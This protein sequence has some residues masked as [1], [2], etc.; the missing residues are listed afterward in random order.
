VINVDL[1][2]SGIEWIGKIP[3][4]WGVRTLKRTAFIHGRIGWQGLTSEEYLDEGNYYLVTGTEFEDGKVNWNDCHYVERDRFQQDI[5]IQLKSDDVL[6]TKDGT[7]GKIALI[8]SLPK[9]ATLNSGVF[10]TRV[11][12][13]EFIPIF[14]YWI[15][16]SDLFP[17]FIEYSKVGTTIN[18]LYQ[19]TFECFIY[20]LPSLY[21]QKLISAYL[22]K[23][24]AIIDK[25]VSVKKKQLEKLEELKK[26]IIYKAVTKGLDDSVEM[27][28]SS[29]EWIGEIP[30][31]WEIKKLKYYIEIKDG[32]H[33]TPTYEETSVGNYPFVTSKDITNNEI[34]FSAVKYIN[35]DYHDNYYKRSNVM[36][37]DIIMPM[38]GT[39]GNSAIVKKEEPFSIK[40]V[41]LFKTSKNEFT[42]TK[43][44]FYFLESELNK[45]QFEIISKGGV[46]EFVS[47]TILRNLYFLKPKIK[48]QKLIVAYLDQ[49]TSEIDSVFEKIT[50]QIEKLKDYKKSL[51][52]ECVTG[53]RRITET[54]IPEAV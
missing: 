48:E 16:I 34:D 18:H 41:A 29:I 28:D 6:I 8:D 40:N 49:K 38:I 15:L 54:E 13:K 47:L 50:L 31:G 52:H 17:Q 1:K 46:Q 26:S 25:A 33:D 22:D 32:T 45:T 20:P 5:K 11:R 42:S 9:P 4:D 51:I 7:I 21:E 27:K 24:T 39:I 14:F 2:D 35:S 30:K 53:K 10:V 12:N 36:K 3:K 19:K 43:Y 44:L 23:I 37:D